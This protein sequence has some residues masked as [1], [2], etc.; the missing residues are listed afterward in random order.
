[1]KTCSLNPRMAYWSPLMRTFRR[2]RRASP[3]SL[4]SPSTRRQAGGVRNRAQNG[5]NGDVCGMRMKGGY[6]AA[7]H[8]LEEPGGRGGRNE[9]KRPAAGQWKTSTRCDREEG[10]MTDCQQGA[11]GICIKRGI[12]GGDSKGHK[13]QS[14]TAW[15]HLTDVREPRRPRAPVAGGDPEE[16][17]LCP[18]RPR[19]HVKHEVVRACLA[20]TQRTHPS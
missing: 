5:P 17:G 10:G 15:P 14:P 7:G 6:Q 16:K 9:A 12:S 18:R 1:V 2:F 4:A 8:F 11:S 20:T 3:S 19:A 13:S